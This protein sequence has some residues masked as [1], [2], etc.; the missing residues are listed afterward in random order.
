MG[1]GVDCHTVG[2]ADRTVTEMG[3]RTAAD[4]DLGG[5]LDRSSIRLLR[6]SWAVAEGTVAADCRTHQHIAA[7]FGMAVVDVA[8]DNCLLVGRT[9]FHHTAGTGDRG[10]TADTAGRWIRDTTERDPGAH[11]HIVTA[12]SLAVAIDRVPVD[13]EFHSFRTGEAARRTAAVAV[14]VAV[15]SNPG[16]SRRSCCPCRKGLEVDTGS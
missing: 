9:D 10:D 6:C 15:D 16:L 11:R 8:T 7:G 12:G 13:R 1:L 3:D 4:W 14:V 2:W 5:S